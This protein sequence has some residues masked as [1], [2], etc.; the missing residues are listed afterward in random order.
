MLSGDVGCG[1][2]SK[3][4]AFPESKRSDE[5]H[6]APLACGSFAR[7]GMKGNFEAIA[8]DRPRLFFQFR[9]FVYFNWTTKS[10]VIDYLR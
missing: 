6:Q 3:L 9:L 2:G 1:I 8:G 10:F 5:Q 4:L 7:L